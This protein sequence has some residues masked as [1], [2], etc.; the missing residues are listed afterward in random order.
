MRG[1]E[2]NDWMVL[3]AIIY[4]IYT[5]EDSVQMR[6]EFLEQLRMVLDFDAADFL[7][8]D[9]GKESERA[10]TVTFGMESAVAAQ[11]SG[12]E[13]DR[14]IPYSG[15]C[16]VYRETDVLSDERRVMT[17][18]YRERFRPNGWHY[19]MQMVLG[20]EGRFL[21]VITFYRTIGRDNFTSEDIF[22]LD[23]L[24]EHLAYRLCQ[25]AG[26][27]GAGS[28]EGKLSV[29]EAAERY[30]LTRREEMVLRALLQGREKEEIAEEFAI[31]VNTLKKHIL[32]L[33][34]KLGISS[35]VQM[36]KMILEK[37]EGKRA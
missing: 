25:D 5:T 4:K 35:R 36:F 1:L 12:M 33:Y 18:R 14:E 30:R 31:S 26:R 34:R 27:R 32:N 2:R 3:N 37:E 22:L 13:D 23:T 17:E 19:A 6:R 29:S 28:G 20:R 21:G 16:M 10:G 9:A 11:R 7:L 8:A 24:K 15:R